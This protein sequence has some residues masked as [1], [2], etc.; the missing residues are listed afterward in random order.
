[1]VGSRQ[2]VLPIDAVY[3]RKPVDENALYQALE[4]QL[5]LC[6]DRADIADAVIN[7]RRPTF[8]QPETEKMV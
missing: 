4:T 5:G 1:M 3:L 8:P 2:M 6:F 7:H